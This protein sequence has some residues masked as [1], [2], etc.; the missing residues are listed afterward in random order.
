MDLPGRNALPDDTHADANLRL[1]AL[2]HFDDADIARQHDQVDRRM[3]VVQGFVVE[4][5]PH[6]AI[7]VVRFFFVVFIAAVVIRRQQ[8]FLDLFVGRGAG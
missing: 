1:A 6:H 8:P 3:P 5:F 2:E 4:G 7:V